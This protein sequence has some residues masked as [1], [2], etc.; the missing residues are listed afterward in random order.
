MKLGLKILLS[1][2]TLFSFQL[3]A[4][5]FQKIDK[6][7]LV[8]KTPVVDFEYFISNDFKSV[9]KIV[10]SWVQAEF[11]TNEDTVYLKLDHPASPGDRFGV[12]KKLDKIDDPSASFSGGYRIQY[13]GNVKVL[14]VKEKVIV[15]KIYNAR[16]N[17]NRGDLIGELMDTNIKIQ[18]HEPKVM[19]RGKVMAPAAPIH[20]SG[21]YEFAFINK[22]SKDGLQV[23]D[24][25]YIYRK[26]TGR[27]G[28]PE[29]DLPEVN[30][31]SLVVVNTSE[32]YSTV[33]SLTGIEPY[34]KG[35]NFKSAMNEVRY[36]D[37]KPEANTEPTAPTN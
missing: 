34:E 14:E 36:L 10:A 3:Q 29:S 8:N 37:Q 20:M 4:E 31:S 32:K 13:L 16:D 24:L 27:K 26:G 7:S 23:N 2:A 33:Y 1:I 9:G 11:L 19:V 25:L 6:L 12:Y 30:V 22:G 15:G 5:E 17:I 21:T 28:I 18:P 35:A